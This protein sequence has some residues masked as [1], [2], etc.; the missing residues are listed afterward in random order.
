MSTALLFRA[1]EAVMLRRYVWRERP[2]KI[3]DLRMAIKL[4]RE[5]TRRLEESRIK[6]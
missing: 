3:R 5:I 2:R 1:Y 4:S 6:L